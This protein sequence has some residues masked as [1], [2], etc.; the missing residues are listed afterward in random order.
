MKILMIN[1]YRDQLGGAEIYIYQLMNELEKRGHA[2][3]FFTSS[4]TKEQYLSPEYNK[5][6]F[7]YLKR[8][9]NI[10]SY[11]DI[12][13]IIEEFKPDIV[14][15]HGIFNELSPSILFP[16]RKRP[17]IMTVHDLQIVTP[18]SLQTSRT[19][20]YCKSEICSGCMNCVGLKGMMFERIKRF[21]H[22]FLL[23][24]IKLYITPSK[25]LEG[26]LRKYDK[27]T[28]VKTVYNGFKLLKHT[29]I[30]NWNRLL[31][32]GRITEEK[33][34]LLLPYV[35]K[36]VLKKIPDIQLNIVGEGVSLEKL[37]YL[38]NSLNLGNHIFIHPLVTRD[39]I[40]ECYNK[41]T[42]VLVPSIFPDILPTVIIE[43]ISVG[44]PVIGS[45]IG[46]IPELI[47]NNEYTGYIIKSGNYLDFAHKI[48]ILINNKI[49][50]DRFSA[51]CHKKAEN[52]Y[53]IRIHVKEIEKI[54][55]NAF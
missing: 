19:G 21:I 47:E 41:T 36:E 5:S 52:K 29:P 33:G 26:I 4:C 16:L 8:I 12:T 20:K 38:V 14:H 55:L 13:K 24:N 49:K 22:T 18:V 2:V 32:V 34:V 40:Q 28:N 51:N 7:S 50:I 43:A 39:K 54:Y 45:N 27:F 35:V 9:F 23:R 37:N 25:Y 15:I 6:F 30:R 46:G 1:D 10:K 44:R 3:R 53:D 31:Y 42:I 17:V 11:I 48:V